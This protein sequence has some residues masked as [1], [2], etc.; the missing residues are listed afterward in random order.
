M[1]MLAI[2]QA[3]MVS[4]MRR[5][6]PPISVIRV[7]WVATRM[8][9]A[10]KNS[11]ILPNAWEALWGFYAVFGFIACT[12]L[13]LVAKEMRKFLMRKEDYYDGDD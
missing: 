12:V 4:G 8:A 9:P 7:L 10:Q 5:P 2:R 11:V 6:S 3:P 1:L 13:I